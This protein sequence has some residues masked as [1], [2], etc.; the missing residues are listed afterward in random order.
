MTSCTA[1]AFGLDPDQ[2]GQV[3][4]FAVEVA[5]RPAA[6]DFDATVVL[7]GRVRVVVETAGK[8]SSPFQAERVCQALMEPLRYRLSRAARCRISAPSPENPL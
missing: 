2:T 3:T 4:P 5:G 8:V 6:A 1:A 7:P